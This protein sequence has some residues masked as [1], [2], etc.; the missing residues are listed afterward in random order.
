MTELLR[1]FGRLFLWLKQLSNAKVLIWR[2]PFFQRSKYYSGSTRVTRLKVA[3]NIA[4][5]TNI[6]HSEST[7]KVKLK[8]Q[9]CRRDPCI[10]WYDRLHIKVMTENVKFIVNNFFS[11]FNIASSPLLHT[12]FS[13]WRVNKRLPQNE[14]SQTAFLRSS[15]SVESVQYTTDWVCDVWS[16]FNL[17]TRVGIP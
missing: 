3:S 6:R 7:L 4:D 14:T 16:S 2:L 15:Q 13:L 9:F 17:V 12:S 10:F 8:S 1:Q 11:I 5:P